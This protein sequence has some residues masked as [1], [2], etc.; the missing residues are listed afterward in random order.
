MP[1]RTALRCSLVALVLLGVAPGQPAG[2]AIRPGRLGIGDSVMLGAKRDLDARGFRIVD[3]VVSRQFYT[4]EGRVL[5]WKRRGALPT[6]VVIHLGNN[7]TV[8]LMDCY[9]AVRDAGPDRN[10][11]LVTLKVPRGWRHIDNQRLGRCA[12]HFA[13]AYLIDWYGYSADH[14]GW[15]YADGYHL[16]PAGRRAYAAFVSQRI[17]ALT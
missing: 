16:R 2:A 7:G 15:F 9:R 5:Y 1:A 10:L 4:V 14:P 11:F 17:S 13:N 8:D 3:A 6:D 12:A